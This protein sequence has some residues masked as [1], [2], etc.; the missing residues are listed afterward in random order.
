MFIVY[1]SMVHWT[2]WL[3]GHAKRSS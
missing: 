1:L 3:F 2:S